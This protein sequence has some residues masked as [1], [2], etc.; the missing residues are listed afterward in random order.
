MKTVRIQ[1]LEGRT[2]RKKPMNSGKWKVQECWW[3]TARKK[4]RPWQE[5]CQVLER[6][7]LD[8]GRYGERNWEKC[9][10]YHQ[11]HIPYLFFTLVRTGN[12]SMTRIAVRLCFTKAPKE[13]GASAPL[14]PAAVSFLFPKLLPILIPQ[15]HKFHHRQLSSFHCRCWTHLGFTRLST[16]ITNM[17]YMGKHEAIQGKD[18]S[19]IKN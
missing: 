9:W 5:R 11:W 7:Y 18:L 6:K 8:S 16:W 3:R 4:K 13:A 2:D 10:Q 1:E 14:H 19:K 12:C 17:D 15:I